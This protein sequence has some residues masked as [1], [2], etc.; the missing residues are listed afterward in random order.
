[1][2]KR[3]IFFTLASKV[4]KFAESPNRKGKQAWRKWKQEWHQRLVSSNIRNL[5]FRYTSTWMKVKLKLETRLSFII[6]IILHFISCLININ[7]FL[8]STLTN[9]MIT[10]KVWKD[11]QTYLLK[12]LRILLYKLHEYSFQISHHV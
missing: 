9:Y 12:E 6:K 7:V 3:V 5:G 8:R 4:C 11:I 1:M 2:I 10:N